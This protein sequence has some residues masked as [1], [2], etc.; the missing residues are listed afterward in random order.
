MKVGQES[1]RVRLQRNNGNQAAP[2]LMAFQPLPAHSTHTQDT[3]QCRCTHTA[4]AVAAAR[5]PASRS[6]P[7]SQPAGRGG[8]GAQRGAL[9][10]S[11]RRHV[12]PGGRP[13]STLAGT[14]ISLCLPP[15]MPWRAGR[16]TQQGAA[17]AR[18]EDTWRAL[19]MT[20]SSPT[21]SAYSWILDTAVSA[22]PHPPTPRLGCAARWPTQTFLNAAAGLACATLPSLAAALAPTPVEQAEGRVIARCVEGAVVICP[23][24][25]QRIQQLHQG[26][27]AVLAG[28]PHTSYHTGVWVVAGVGVGGR[29]QCAM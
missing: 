1:S 15:R 7:T 20:C 11:T 27:G 3:V 21:R 6:Q 16:A 23:R 19:Q 17:G 10:A 2:P 29:R 5:Q 28:R 25:A 14:Q 13:H 4:V 24:K 18:T 22:P 12:Q 8:G 26:G 9:P